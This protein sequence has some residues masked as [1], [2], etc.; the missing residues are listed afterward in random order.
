MRMVGWYCKSRKMA[1]KWLREREQRKEKETRRNMSRTKG[2]IFF[3]IP[4]KKKKSQA[5]IYCFETC[6]SCVLWKLATPEQRTCR[7][8]NEEWKK[9]YVI[10]IHKLIIWI[11]QFKSTQHRAQENKTHK[12]LAS[13]FGVYNQW[14]S[15]NDDFRRNFVL[16][17]F[18]SARME[19]V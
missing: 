3:F 11:M 13:L 1:G 4:M 8:F 16:F 19:S 18:C 6:P 2:V 5:A 7:A 9:I 12:S 10:I 14:V 17:F 15:W